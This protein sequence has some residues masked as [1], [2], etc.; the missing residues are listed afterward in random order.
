MTQRSVLHINENWTFRQADDENTSFLPVSQFPTNVHLDLVANG[1]IREP[2]F[3]K[4]EDELQWVGEEAWEYQTSFV[5]PS[6][7]DKK[8][9]LV[10]EGLDTYSS[11][12]LNGIDI[13]KT[14][15]MFVPERVDVTDHLRYGE[16]N[17]LKIRFE[18]AYL[19]GKK[20]VEKYAYYHWGCWNGDPSRLAVRKAQY[21]YVR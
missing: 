17:Q 4:N 20:M 14:R 1:L 16:D 12:S 7:I 13:L 3:S 5:G 15:N 2:F 11:V 6:R 10:F 19:M 9:F 8:A 21:H 18:S